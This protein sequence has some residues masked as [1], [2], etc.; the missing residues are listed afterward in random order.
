MQGKTMQVLKQAQTTIQRHRLL[1]E[2]DTVLVGVSGGGDSV[3]LL[4]ILQKLK[5][6]L[7]ITLSVAHIHHG[8]RGEEA[9]RDAVF[10]RELCKAWKIPF[11]LRKV[12]VPDFAEKEDLSLETAGRVLRYQCFRDLCEVKGIRKIA[13][14]HNQND[15]A[16][17][18]LM[19]VLRGTGI[20][21][22]AGIRYKRE[23]GVIRPLLDVSRED[24]EAYLEENHLE[25]CTDSTNQEDEYSRNRIR[26]QLMPQLMEQF[27]PKLL[28]ALSSL[29]KNM[30]EDG[31]FLK[32]YASRFYKRLGSPLPNRRP[33]VLEMESLEMLERS[34]KVR[35][36]KLAAEDAMGRGYKAERKHWES[37]LGLLS[38][39]TG[40]RVVLPGGLTVS[41]GYGWL[42]FE[43]PEEAEKKIS[44]FE[45]VTVEPEHS[46]PVPE[47]TVSFALAE[48]TKQLLENQ[49]MLDYEKLDG[50]PLELRTRRDGDRIAVYRDGRDKKL[51][52]FLI[53]EKIP[54]E[55]RDK[56]MLVC[57][58]N[59]V[60]LIPGYRIAEPYKVDSNTKNGLVVTYDKN[61]EGR[62]NFADGGAD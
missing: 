14:A 1:E 51:K 20:E 55:E 30:A 19:R 37:V 57:N 27:N 46:Y 25:Y 42:I 32:G 15:Q 39:E 45:A 56:L 9:D 38:K 23:D 6:E 41:V 60:V 34:L 62:R 47:G 31:D 22:L 50:L 8:I 28:Q 43:I 13:T 3:C 16:E 53:D 59:Q 4:H 7:G 10:V 17:T 33:V 48:P 2:G 24:I 49:W 58:G 54:R 40:S 52:D 26:H 36:C 21:G 29:A 12:S 5:E 61:N 18:V 35:L 11:S 44:T